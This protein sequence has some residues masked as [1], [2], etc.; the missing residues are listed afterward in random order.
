MQGCD[1]SAES[2]PEWMA[3]SGPPLGQPVA[4]SKDGRFFVQTMGSTSLRS[5]RFETSQN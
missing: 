1:P 2:S 4:P 3:A 5:R